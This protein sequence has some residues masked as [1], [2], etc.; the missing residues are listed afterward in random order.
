MIFFNWPDVATALLRMRGIHTGWWRVGLQ[1]DLHGANVKI[2]TGKAT[3]TKVPAAFIPAVNVN[4]QEVK[5]DAVDELCVNA[6]VVN[7]RPNLIV[8]VGG[9]VN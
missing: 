2:P 3:H 1:F 5:D 8:P 6:A 7:P 9:L 4:I